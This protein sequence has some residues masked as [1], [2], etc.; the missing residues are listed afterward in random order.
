MKGNRF[1]DTIK[2]YARKLTDDDLR[3]PPDEIVTANR[4]RFG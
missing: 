3:L 1:S 4:T 2:E